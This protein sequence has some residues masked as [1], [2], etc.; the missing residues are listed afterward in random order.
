MTIG[1]MRFPGPGCVVE[2]L[3]GNSVA[4]AFVLGEQSGRLRLYGTNRRESALQASRLLP[5][6]GPSLR[7]DFSRKEIEDAL[8]A[9]SRLRDK[10]AEG[11]NVL[12]L[13]ET[14]NEDMDKVSAAW[15]A[16]LVWSAPTVDHEAAVGRALLACRTH[17]RFA[18]PDFEVFSAGQ[19]EKRIEEARLAEE[20]EALTGAG[21]GFFRKLWDMHQKGLRGASGSELPDQ[22][23]AARL[24]DLLLRR[25]VSPED[26]ESESTWKQLVG[27]LPDSP[28]LAL[29]LAVA[30]GLVPEHHNFMLDRAGYESGE[31]WADA[32]GRDCAALETKV[33]AAAGQAE[34]EAAVEP[35]AF[36]SID[37][38]QALD[39]DDAFFTAKDPEGGWR[40][41]IALASPAQ[42][43][44]FGCGL[45]KATL[46]R[47]TS[48]YLP[49]GVEHMLPE[50]AGRGLFSLDAGKT[51]PAL[52]FDIAF[53]PDGTVETCEMRP[54]FVNVAANL[55]LQE[56][57]ALLGKT[58]PEQ[59]A[60]PLS[61]KELFDKAL[62]DETPQENEG[63]NRADFRQTGHGRKNPDRADW[64]QNS[65]SQEQTAQNSHNQEQAAQDS[66]GRGQ[67]AQDSHNQEQAAQAGSVRPVFLA[68]PSPAAAVHASMLKDAQALAH[69]L[70]SWRIRA[71]AVITE[72]PDPEIVLHDRGQGV[73]VSIFSGP[74]TPEAQTIVGEFMILA[75]GLAGDKACEWGIP[76]LHRT[77]DVALPKEY[78]GIWTEPHEISKVVRSMPPATLQIQAKRHAGLGLARYAPLTSPIRRYTDL[79]NQGQVI[80]YLRHREP[81]FDQSALAA[82]FPL[83]CARLDEVGQIQRMRPRYWKFLFFRQNGDKKWWDAVITEENENFVFASLPWAQLIIRA[84]RQLFGEKAY[85][86][87]RVQVRL[88]KVNPLLNEIMILES[89]EY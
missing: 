35:F 72:R 41:L 1:K 40:L 66:H 18:P 32:F 34:A 15:L 50:R 49:E 3:Q 65:H 2:Y 39:R 27:G 21:I 51:R 83:V 13:W 37:P 30:W 89:R 73:E 57:E 20:R 76:L 80:H 45:D 56:A 87:Q 28:N 64:A 47:A 67:A 84:K 31:A 43:W 9:Q 7:A 44:D 29:H 17:F 38:E 11:I 75:N 82:I 71:G 61:D 63:L 74:E 10:L 16:G 77:Q 68:V 23:L 58:P 8:E 19:A 59:E 86:G 12:E 62:L 48:I 85:P 81:L 53:S 78:A 24:K 36:V 46:R 52:V 55:S 4:T 14:I 70:R 79:L 60:G 33:R 22:D 26:S 5:W 69:I 25:I 42:A 54:S 88:G 6:S